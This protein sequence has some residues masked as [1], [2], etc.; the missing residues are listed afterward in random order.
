MRVDRRYGPK[1]GASTPLAVSVAYFTRAGLAVADSHSGCDMHIDQ[2][3]GKLAK[4]DRT[5]AKLT[6]IPCGL[7]IPIRKDPRAATF[8][9]S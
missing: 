1:R 7:I 2:S 5:V 4:A 6:Q 8:L 3:E 9:Q